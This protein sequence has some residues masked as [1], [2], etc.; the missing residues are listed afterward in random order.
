MPRLSFHRTRTV[1]WAAHREARLGKD[2]SPWTASL[3]G[4]DVAKDRLDVAVRPSGEVFI[5]ERNAAGLELLVRAIAGH[6]AAARR[7][8]SHRRLRD[9]GG[10]GAGRRRPAGRRRQSGPGPRLRQGD[11]PARQDRS[12]RRG[13]HR[14]LRRGDQARAAPAARRSHAAA[15]RSRCAPA[16]DR[17]DDRRRAP[18]RAAHHGTRLKKSIARLIKALEKELA[19]VDADIDDAVRGSPAWRDKEDLLASVPGVG[20]IIA[21]TLIAELPELGSSTAR[22]SP[23]SPGLRP[24]PAS[25]ANGAAEA[26]S[27]ADEPACAPPSS[28]APWSPSGT[29]PS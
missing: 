15:G 20:P 4:I 7:P 25:P 27:A 23:P 17:R 26:S 16:A 13:R 24:S 6:V 28:W 12:D 14:P 29:T 18:A 3:V 21:R 8:G 9:G 5:V 22:R 2:G 1:A 10:G 11:R 19:S